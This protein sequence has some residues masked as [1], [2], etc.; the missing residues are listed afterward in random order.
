MEVVTVPYTVRYDCLIK[1]SIKVTDIMEK[2]YQ[3]KAIS[4][5]HQS[6]GHKISAAIYLVTNHVPD[7]DP[8]KHALRHK[9]VAFASVQDYSGTLIADILA[10][11]EVAVLSGIIRQQNA[12][13]ISQELLAYRARLGADTSTIAHLFE[14]EQVPQTP[15]RM[16]FSQVSS[17]QT[18][19]KNNINNEQK[20]KR[21]SDI[22]SFINQRKSVVIKDIA[23]LFPDVSEKTIQRELGALVESGKITKR[24]SKRWSIYLAVS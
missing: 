10:L 2:T 15:A 7:A 23:A 3:N 14:T 4:T 5:P 16:S 24:G 20:N 18:I 13:L 19:Q 1:D 6:K 11:L 22:L 12:L 21:Q 9:A 17:Y 8:I